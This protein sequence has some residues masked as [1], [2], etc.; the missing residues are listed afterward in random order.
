[1]GMVRI[2]HGAKIDW[3]SV[4]RLLATLPIGTIQSR[5]QIEKDSRREEGAREEEEER[6]IEEECLEFRVHTDSSYMLSSPHSCYLI[7]SL[8]PFWPGHIWIGPRCSVAF[9]SC[10][11]TSCC[12]SFW[13]SPLSSS[14]NSYKIIGTS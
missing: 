4:T 12:C 11:R 7:H 14:A 1:V 2:Q 10:F 5:D 8:H 9:G 6:V 13:A 3:V